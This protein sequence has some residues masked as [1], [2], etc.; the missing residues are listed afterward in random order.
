MSY[1]RKF[2]S[3]EIWIEDRAYRDALVEIA[4][5]A[6]QLAAKNE[7]IQ[8]L[9]ADSA[10]MRAEHVE[11]LKMGRDYCELIYSVASKFEGETRHETAL[12]YIRQAERPDAQT[13]SAALSPAQPQNNLP[14]AAEN[15]GTPLAAGP[16]QENKTT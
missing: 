6:G 16:N 13:Q 7:E 14:A 10:I 3:G 4:K 8:R 11:H 12:R 5:L 2:F 15:T 1:Q 9:V